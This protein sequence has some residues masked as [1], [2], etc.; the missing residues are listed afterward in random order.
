VKPDNHPAC[1]FPLINGRYE[2]KPGMMPFG[3]CLGN[4]EADQQV[5]QIDGHFTHYRQNKILARGERLSKYYQTCNYSPAV[6]GAIACLIIERL[7]LEHPQYFDCQKIANTLQFHSRLTQ[8][9]LYLDADWQL[10]QVQGSSVIPP[11]VSTLDALAAQIQEDI[12]VI[13]RSQDGSNWLSAVHL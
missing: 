6:A 4:G 2:V 12:T 9:T 10:Q 3:C 11:Y 13:C 8:E 7:T 5:F 1:Y